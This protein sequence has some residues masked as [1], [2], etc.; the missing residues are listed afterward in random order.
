MIDIFDQFY[1]DCLGSRAIFEQL[2]D[3]ITWPALEKLDDFEY[4][5][6]TALARFFHTRKS[7]LSIT[8]CEGIALVIT[9]T[10]TELLWLSLS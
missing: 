10:I 5:V 2:L 4:Q 6:I 8:K 7:S 9:K 3:T 1:T